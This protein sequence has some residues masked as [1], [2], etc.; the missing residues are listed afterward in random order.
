MIQD[1]I[2]MQGLYYTFIIY[3]YNLNAVPFGY[4]KYIQS[5]V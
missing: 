2:I 4:N 1:K 3:W 5:R